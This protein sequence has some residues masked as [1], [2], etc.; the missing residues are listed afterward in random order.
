[1]PIS[2]TCLTHIHSDHP[3]TI[4][5]ITHLLGNI[6][7]IYWKS[8]KKILLLQQNYNL[9]IH[10]NKNKNPN[11]S[12]KWQILRLPDITDKHDKCSLT[13]G[14]MIMMMPWWMLESI[15]LGSYCS[16]LIERGFRC[17]YQWPGHHLKIIHV[18][19]SI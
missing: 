13:P 12:S 5:N 10:K 1:M 18:C 17:D 11:S 4:M 6:A 14:H 16:M 19:T 3:A 2:L 8:L 7:H 9:Y 15:Y